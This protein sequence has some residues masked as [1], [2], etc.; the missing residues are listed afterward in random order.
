MFLRKLFCINPTTPGSM[1]SKSLYYILSYVQT[2]RTTPNIVVPTTLGVV[3]CILAVVCKW[4]QQLPTM[5]GPSVHHGKD[6][7]KETVHNEHV[8]PQQCWKSCANGSNIVALCFGNHRA[9]EML[10]VVGSNFDRFETLH[11][12]MQNRVC[13]WT[14]HVTSKNVGR[15]LLTMLCLF[16][17]S[18]MCMTCT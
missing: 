14:Q 1:S 6:T 4:M 10:G 5:W 18:P 15:F 12:G 11:N 3:G 7:M 13:K 9:K 17:R 8:W 2:H 16:A